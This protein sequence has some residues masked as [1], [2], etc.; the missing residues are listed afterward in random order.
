MTTSACNLKRIRKLVRCFLPVTKEQKH[1]MR[2]KKKQKMLHSIVQFLIP[3]AQGGQ[4]VRSK[5]RRIC[6][7]VG[8]QGTIVGIKAVR[9]RPIEEG[10]SCQGSVLGERIG[11]REKLLVERGGAVDVGKHYGEFARLGLL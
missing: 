7:V 10:Q 9:I 2:S 11:R 3:R 8:I 5:V 6:L 1:K 4:V